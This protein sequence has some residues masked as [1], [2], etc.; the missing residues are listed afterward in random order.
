MVGDN[1]SKII[2]INECSPLCRRY[3]TGGMTNSGYNIG[4]FSGICILPT[5]DRYLSGE[6]DVVI[7]D[8]IVNNTNEEF[9]HYISSTTRVRTCSGPVIVDFPETIYIDAV[10]GTYIT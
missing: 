2:K 1:M 7:K 9:V 4:C 6:K 5:L 8:V 3:N 10:C